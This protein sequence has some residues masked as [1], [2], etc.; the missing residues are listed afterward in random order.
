MFGGDKGHNL[1]LMSLDSNTQ[2]D[3][4]G[5][6]LPHSTPY[7]TPNSSGVNYFNQDLSV[8]DGVRVNAYVFLPF[9]LM[10]PLLRFLQTKRADV[11]VVVSERSPLPSGLVQ[12]VAYGQRYASAEGFIFKAG[13]TKHSL[14][15]TKQSF[16]PGPSSTFRLFSF[17]GSKIA[18]P[19]MISGLPRQIFDFAS[20]CGYQRQRTLKKTF[21]ATFKAPVDL[22][23]IETRKQG[24]LKFKQSYPYAKHVLL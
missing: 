16:K 1:D 21:P 12:L 8:G 5:N 20:V 10:S 17:A 13:F 3:M 6:S 19:F 15:P 7:P 23:K 22:S 11:T 4:C 18:R 9:P 24:V 2:R 14:F